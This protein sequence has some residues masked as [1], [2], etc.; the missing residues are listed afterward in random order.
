MPVGTPERFPDQN[1]PKPA[2]KKNKKFEKK[3]QGFQDVL[4]ICGHDFKDFN[5]NFDRIQD[6]AF[7][8]V[9]LLFVT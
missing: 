2:F 1:L 4:I 9:W 8:A 5:G 7:R 6:I 3:H